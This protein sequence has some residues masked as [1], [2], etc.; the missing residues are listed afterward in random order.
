MVTNSVNGTG[1]DN[2]VVVVKK[3]KKNPY[4]GR[5]KEARTFYKRIETLRQKRRI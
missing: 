2:S 3:K 5:T 1:D 4:D